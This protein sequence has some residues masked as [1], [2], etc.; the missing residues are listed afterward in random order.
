MRLHLMQYTTN[1]APATP[2]PKERGVH[3]YQEQ[4]SGEMVYYAVTSKGQLLNGELRR[5]IVEHETHAMILDEMRR[6]L[7]RQDP[8]PEVNAPRRLSVSSGGLHRPGRGGP[9][10]P[11]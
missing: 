1:I 7:D 11:A 6:D 4:P 9:S 3:S 2:A 8:V 5:R 10:R